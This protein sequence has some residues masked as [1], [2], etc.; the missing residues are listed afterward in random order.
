MTHPRRTPAPRNAGA[1]LLLAPMALIALL[2]GGCGIPNRGA[3]PREASPATRSLVLSPVASL[4]P[5]P[6]SS[7]TLMA[8]SSP[9]ASGSPAEDD[10][11]RPALPA[12]FPVM[13]AASPLPLPVDPSVI[14]QWSV[15]LVG[16][17]PYDFYLAALPA[18]G[19]PIVGR[20]PAERAALIRFEPRPGVVW[21]LLIEQAGDATRLSVQADRP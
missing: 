1:A 12:A 5:S 9:V 20:Y 2:L 8:L 17:Q 7:P 19:Y 4:G 14:A 3:T 16:S 13:P 6:A 10:G 15:P 21:Q 11:E 18:A